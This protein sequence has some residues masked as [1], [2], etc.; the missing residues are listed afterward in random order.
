MG[1]G[2]TRHRNL[3]GGSEAWKRFADIVGDGG[4]PVSLAADVARKLGP[5]GLF[6]TRGEDCTAARHHIGPLMHDAD[7]LHRDRIV[8]H[9]NM[10]LTF[11]LHLLHGDA[12]VLLR[13]HGRRMKAKNILRVQECVEL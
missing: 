13:L 9:C 11:R 6:V 3:V 2:R 1:D 12:E 4:G 8:D 10:I 5:F 7:Q